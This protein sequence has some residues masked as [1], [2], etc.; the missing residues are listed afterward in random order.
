MQ[1]YVIIWEE[2]ARVSWIW[3]KIIRIFDEYLVNFF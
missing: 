2:Y 3:N 1:E